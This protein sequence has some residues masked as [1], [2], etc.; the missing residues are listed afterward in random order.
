M[1]INIQSESVDQT[2][3]T[4]SRISQQMKVKGLEE[5]KPKEIYNVSIFLTWYLYWII[6]YILILFSHSFQIM[7]DDYQISNLE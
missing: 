3:T 5:L 2:F 7:L 6:L 1:K 4:L